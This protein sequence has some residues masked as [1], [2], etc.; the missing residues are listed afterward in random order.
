MIHFNL[1]RK[2][3]I[4]CKKLLAM[5]SHELFSDDREF[6]VYVNGKRYFD[7]LYF[8]ILE[9]TLYAIEWKCKY[10]KTKADF[11]YNTLDDSQNPLLAFIHV[12]NGWKIYSI[13]QEFECESVFSTDELM[14]FIDCII[15]TVTEH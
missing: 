1:A 8:P 7:D 14:E 3:A 5:T 2:E 9:F 11:V 12:N 4:P 6:T 15:S 13:W 10:K